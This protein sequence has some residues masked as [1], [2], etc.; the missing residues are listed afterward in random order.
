MGVQYLEL[1]CMIDQALGHPEKGIVNLNMLHSLLHE[2][3]NH[4]DNRTTKESINNET[5]DAQKDQT[6]Y[7]SEIKLSNQ[8]LS[9][10]DSGPTTR[11]D[12]GVQKSPQIFQRYG[13][14]CFPNGKYR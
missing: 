9:E 2:I 5:K 11:D 8:L 12:F 13:Y 3:L 6:A 4:L 7:Q 1:R 14:C 10:L